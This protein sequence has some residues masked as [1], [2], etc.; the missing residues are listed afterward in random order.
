M[1]LGPK[2]R[3][4][5]RLGGAEGSDTGSTPLLL[6]SDDNRSILLLLRFLH[7]VDEDG[8]TPQLALFSQIF[9]NVVQISASREQPD[10]YACRPPACPQSGGES[11]KPSSRGGWNLYRSAPFRRPVCITG[12]LALAC[13]SA[14][15]SG[16]L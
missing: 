11:F 13:C 9:A 4:S 1:L 10:I 3:S 5:S 7:A 14:F 2:N 15:V 8:C 6:T 12:I 16:L